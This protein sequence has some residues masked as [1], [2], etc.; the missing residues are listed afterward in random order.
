M[1]QPENRFDFKVLGR[2]CR[3]WRRFPSVK[4][5]IMVENHTDYFLLGWRVFFFN[6]WYHEDLSLCCWQLMLTSTYLYSWQ[7]MLMYI[8]IVDKWCCLLLLL[9][10]NNVYFSLFWFQIMFLVAMLISWLIL[11]M[12][13][14]NHVVFS[15]YC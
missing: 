11:V 6:S 7:I 1:I 14:I 15:L 8:C 9:L 12:L 10:T 13:L 4:L 5:R 3:R 2:C